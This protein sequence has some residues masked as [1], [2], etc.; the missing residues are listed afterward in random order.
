[1]SKYFRNSQVLRL[2]TGLLHDSPSPSISST[3]QVGAL[4]HA[5]HRGS[6]EIALLS[7]TAWPCSSS[8]S[9]SSLAVRIKSRRCRWKRSLVGSTMVIYRPFEHHDLKHSAIH[10]LTLKLLIVQICPHDSSPGL[11]IV[12]YNPSEHSQIATFVQD[13]CIL[14]F[15]PQKYLISKTYPKLVKKIIRKCNPLDKLVNKFITNPKII[16]SV[17]TYNK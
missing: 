4:L 7:S 9:G 16:I 6:S 2:V 3:L 17:N 11:L 8:P 10:A 5:I 15:M 14:S 1:M 13:S 12:Q